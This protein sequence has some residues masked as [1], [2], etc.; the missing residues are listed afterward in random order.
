MDC[1]GVLGLCAKDAKGTAKKATTINGTI[2][3]IIRFPPLDIVAGSPPGFLMLE[4]LQEA[5]T[6][7]I[8]YI[9]FHAKL[10]QTPPKK[11]HYLPG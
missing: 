10:T 3:F 11:P 8:R 6:L 5:C 7:S 1:S 4:M 2:F 9:C